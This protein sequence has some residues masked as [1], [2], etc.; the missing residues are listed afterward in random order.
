MVSAVSEPEDST[1]QRLLERLDEVRRLRGETK[2][3]VAR[4]AGL[5]EPAVRRLFS[6]KYGNPTVRTLGALAG[7]LGLRLTLEAQ[8]RVLER[9]TLAELRANAD[10]I[11][12][13][14]NKHGGRN[15]RIFGSVARGDALLGSD[16]DVL[17][18]V[19]LGTGLLEVG[20]MEDELE[21]ALG[22]HFDVVTSG[23]G[24][25]AHIQDEAVSL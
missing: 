2:A 8:P 16:V 24:V 5:S 12:R 6:A 1:T 9:P 22:H 19:R 7:H 13:I 21:Q 20:A 23:H 11:G 14:I 17:V 3:A 15:I 25:M 4:S 10:E 18:D